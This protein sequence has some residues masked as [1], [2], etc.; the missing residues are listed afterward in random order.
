MLHS[1]PELQRVFLVAFEHSF[2]ASQFP[3][4]S[5]AKPNSCAHNKFRMIG[6]RLDPRR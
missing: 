5:A 6:R 2:A 3:L 1:A 4:Y